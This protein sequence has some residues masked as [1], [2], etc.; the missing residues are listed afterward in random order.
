MVSASVMLLF[1]LQNLKKSWKLAEISLR[2]NYFKAY[3]SLAELILR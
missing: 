2:L 3:F 1:G